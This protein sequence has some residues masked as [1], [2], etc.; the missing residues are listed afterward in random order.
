M[1][2]QHVPCNFC[3]HHCKS[4]IATTKVR[5]LGVPRF[6][7]AGNA[8]GNSRIEPYQRP[9][10]NSYQAPA[11]TAGDRPLRAENQA[12]FSAGSISCCRSFGGLLVDVNGDLPVLLAAKSPVSV[13]CSTAFNDQFCIAHF[14]FPDPSAIG[15]A[16]VKG[17]FGSKLSNFGPAQFWP[18]S[19]ARA[20]LTDIRGQHWVVEALTHSPRATSSPGTAV[21]QSRGSDP[22]LTAADNPACR[23]YPAAQRMARRSRHSALLKRIPTIGSQQRLSTRRSKALRRAATVS[24]PLRWF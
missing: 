3:Y 9:H 5:A 10:R 17:S 22:S 23:G 2:F 1:A 20:P 19:S 12:D 7:W 18:N 21:L 4:L 8:L 24:P 11:C 15:V 14:C 13:S 16:E 6:K